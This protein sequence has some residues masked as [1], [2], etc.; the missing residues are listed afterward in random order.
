MQNLAEVKLLAQL[1]HP[2]IVAYK[3]AWLEPVSPTK[4]NKHFFSHIDQWPTEIRL[5]LVTVL[6][7]I[8]YMTTLFAN[9]INDGVFDEVGD[10]ISKFAIISQRCI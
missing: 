10:G 5:V 9:V 3:A 4:E 8:V 2:N 7:L 1:N 6:C